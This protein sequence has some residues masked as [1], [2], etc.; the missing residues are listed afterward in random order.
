[1]AFKEAANRKIRAFKRTV[2]FDRK[3]SILTAGRVEATTL[4]DPRADQKTVPAD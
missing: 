4:A 2:F 1:M 3:N